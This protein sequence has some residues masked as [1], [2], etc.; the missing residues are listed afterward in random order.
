MTKIV[1]N[2]MITQRQASTA[3]PV[4]KL[5]GFTICQVDTGCAER[6][7][8]PTFIFLLPSWKLQPIKTKNITN[9][10]KDDILLIFNSSM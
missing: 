8:A 9:D 4:M 7:N 5:K 10:L 2:R 3:T 1:M 6:S